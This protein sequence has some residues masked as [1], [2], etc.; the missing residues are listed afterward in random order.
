MANHK[1]KSHQ[2]AT[3]HQADISAS[4]AVPESIQMIL[5]PYT[6]QTQH[7]YHNVN[8]LVW[9]AMQ[10]ADIP[11]F[12]EPY[13]LVWP[14]QMANDRSARFGKITLRPGT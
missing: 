8:D 10:K 11:F 13:G 2:I 5:A 3:G 1:N 9:R 6:V 12:K 4:N 14:H 7:S